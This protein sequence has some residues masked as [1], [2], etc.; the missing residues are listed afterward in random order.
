EPSAAT[1][2]APE[3]ERRTI[4][5]H[6]GTMPVHGHVASLTYSMEDAERRFISE[7][8]GL[9]QDFQQDLRQQLAA[10]E[11]SIVARVKA[12]LINLFPAG[13]ANAEDVC[14][15]LAVSRSTLQRALR[16]EGTHFQAILD[17]TRQ[18]LAMR[19][20]RKS[21]LT[22]REIA[23]LVGYRDPNSF[24]RSFKRW[25]GRT[26]GSFRALVGDGSA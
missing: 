20:L 9:W 15:E 26:P 23:L 3:G 7:N 14:F 24:T 8:P 11:L 17:D 22:V 19:Y 2:P 1:L 5:E 25:T 21:V 18:E 16:A 13:R 12:A 4:A 10:Q 6:L